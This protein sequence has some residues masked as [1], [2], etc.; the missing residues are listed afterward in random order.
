MTN[1]QT[2]AIDVPSGLTSLSFKG[3]DGSTTGLDT[4]KNLLGS[5]L[6][7]TIQGL[8][9]SHIPVTITVQVKNNRTF[10]QYSLDVSGGSVQNVP[11]STLAGV[12]N[13]EMFCNEI[14]SGYYFG[15][16]VTQFTIFN[17]AP[18]KVNPPSD[19]LTSL[20]IVSY[21][22]KTTTLDITTPL[23]AFQGQ[24]IQ[25]FFNNT[26][27]LPIGF[28]LTGG[29]GQPYGLGVTDLNGNS[30]FLSN[31]NGKPNF[32]MY[33]N[34]AALGSYFGQEVPS[35]SILKIYPAIVVAQP[36]AQTTSCYSGATYPCPYVIPHLGKYFAEITTMSFI[37]ASGQVYS[38]SG[39]QIAQINAYYQKMMPNSE[40]SIRVKHHPTYDEV[41]GLMAN[42]KPLLLCT[43]PNAGGMGF[44]M[45]FY[46]NNS[47]IATVAAVTHAANVNG[48][49]FAV[50]QK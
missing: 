11:I 33:Y 25:E 3:S 47:L 9:S 15:P 28:Y 36:E 43:I 6:N 30:N 35:F 21:D 32:E 16:G 40:V 24:T 10:E 45:K 20:T 31:L 29:S 22:S 4:N 44:P 7:A 38:V 27:N 8:F 14:S 13:F 17:S 26:Y 19:G 18:I 50:L 42:V 1:G 23:S 37:Q 48:N 46:L 41:F 34:G 2:I 5:N 49:L 12:P 39:A